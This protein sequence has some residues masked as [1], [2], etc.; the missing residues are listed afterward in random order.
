V[1]VKLAKTAGFCMGVRRAMEKVLSEA[2]KGG[3]PLYTFGPLIHNKQVLD[4][5][6]SK[7]VGSIHKLDRARDGRVVIRAHGI[8]P[9]QRQAIRKSGAK[10]IDAT[11]P[12]VARVQA[13]IRYYSSKGYCAVIVGDRDHAEVEGLMGYARGEVYVIQGPEDVSSLPEFP[14]AFAVAQTTQN[15]RNYT[16]VAKRLRARFPHILIFD[17]VC[18]TTHQR[19]QEVRSFAGQ[20]DAVVVVGG[21][22]SANTQRL[23]EVSREAGLP[24][25]HVETGKDLNKERLQGM[26]VIGV[27]AGASTPN[28]MIK[29]IVREIE[30]VRGRRESSLIRRLKEVYKFVVLSN[31]LVASCA[32]SFSYA[33]LVLCDTVRDMRFP[34]LAFLYILAMYTL[35]RFL[36]R[37]ASAYNDPERAAFLR[38]HRPLLVMVGVGC[39]CGAMI[40]SYHIGPTTLLSMAGL[41]SL[42]IVYSVP[43][44]PKRMREKWRYSKIKDVPGSRSISEALA[45]GAIITVLPLL[46]GDRILWPVWVACVSVVLLMA[47]CRSA[48]FDIF[49]AQGDLIVGTET[50]PITIGENRTLGLL[51]GVLTAVGVVLFVGPFLGLASGFAYLLLLPVFGFS[52]CLVAYERR[53]LLP[54]TAFEGLVEGNLFVTGVLAYLWQRI[55]WPP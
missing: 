16:E 52:L 50:L 4:L 38:R 47:F 26:E 51:K 54:G 49:Q 37:G 22:H 46:E 10:V 14:R 42:G 53:W 33:S 24:T 11:C 5:L 39:I 55:S 17:T 48:I 27:T 20:V 13:I 35:N 3:D 41:S 21:Y 23:A 19:Q 34:C 40:V 9:A 12:R 18:E 44:L 25:F 8:P 7:G 36:D 32:F 6:E 29:E 31:L 28:W 1:R 30:S 45:W 2:N 43:L 15:E